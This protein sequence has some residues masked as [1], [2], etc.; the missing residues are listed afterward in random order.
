MLL[1]LKR[2]LP[3]EGWLTER[4]AR[5]RVQAYR[6]RQ[7]HVARI[8]E[9][10]DLIKDL[11]PEARKQASQQLKDCY[12]ELNLDLRLERLDKAVAINE[13]KIRELTRAAEQYTAR[14]E[15]RKLHQVL[16]EA[17][18]LQKHNSRLFKTIER[19]EEKL[20]KAAKR[21]AKDAR[22]VSDA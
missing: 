2:M 22:G 12:K 14:H 16:E 4:L 18:Q 7:G 3:A 1:Q 21:V 11:P 20:Q 10:R 19:T 5:L 8:D 6:A 15:H 13:K 9:I 17:E